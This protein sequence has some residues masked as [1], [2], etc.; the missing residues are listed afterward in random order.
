MKVATKPLLYLGINDAENIIKWVQSYVHEKSIM[1]RNNLYYTSRQGRRWI[2][3]G[4]KDKYVLITNIIKEIE[5][6]ENNEDA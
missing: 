6:E 1:K 4:L 5:I 2:M 3:N